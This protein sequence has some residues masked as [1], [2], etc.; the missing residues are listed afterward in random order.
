MRSNFTI[1]VT[2]DKELQD[3][4]QRLSRSVQDRINSIAI[5]K[6]GEV[7]KKEILNSITSSGI[8]EHSGNLRKSI[9]QMKAKIARNSRET[10]IYAQKKRGFHAHLLEY[11][12]KLVTWDKQPFNSTTKRFGRPAKFGNKLISQGFV[13]ARPFFRPAV[14]KSEAEVVKVY[15]QEVMRGIEAEVPSI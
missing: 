4:L 5:N 14:D 13:R 12:H 1:D 11:G 7:I 9:M 10:I 6:A 8:K 3:T 15:S 2:G